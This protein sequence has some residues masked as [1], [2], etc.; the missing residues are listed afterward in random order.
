[1][2]SFIY[3]EFSGVGRG[4][5]AALLLAAATLPA[6]V[7]ADD[8]D[9]FWVAVRNDRPAVVQQVFKRGAIGPNAKNTATNVPLIEAIKYDSWKVYDLLLKDKRIDLNARNRVGETPLMYLA[10]KGDIARMKDLIG[11]GAEV[12]QTGWTALHY[13]ATAGHDDAVRLLLENYAYIDAESPEKNT[14]MM[15]AMKY[16]RGTT[17][18]LLLD[19]GADGYFRNAAGQNAADMAREAGNSAL[20]NDFVERLNIERRRKMQGR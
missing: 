20:A 10:I 11:R 9:D 14:P 3:S 17:V 15:M 4:L 12:N 1:M 5:L 16:N 2:K 18:K 19:E 7:R 13:A 6:L 8:A